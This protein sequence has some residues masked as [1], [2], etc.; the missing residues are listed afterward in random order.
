VLTEWSQARLASSL[1][2]TQVER[3]P[4]GVDPAVFAP[5]PEAGQLV[6]RRLGIAADAPVVVCVSR[7][8]PRK[9]QDT[10]IRALPELRRRVPG[11]VLLLVGGGPSRDRLEN[12]AGPGVVMTGSV[13]REEL[14]WHYAAGDVFAMPCR[15][16]L[17][18]L[19]VEGLGLVYLEASAMGLPVVGGRSG[20]APDA[21]QEGITGVTVDSSEE[22]GAVLERL[23]L[24][25]KERERM[26]AAGRDWVKREWDWDDLAARWGHLVRADD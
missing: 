9:G 1:R 4:G 2:G 6:R 24:D 10:L 22:L 15:T 17:G 23:L 19:D 21:L 11:T 26:G 3:L 16:R 5:D 18:G 13:A 8:M 25:P 20:G 12:L 7:L 14:P